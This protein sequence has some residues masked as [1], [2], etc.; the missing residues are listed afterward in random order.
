MGRASLSV[1][2]LP[3]TD[4]ALP[5]ARSTVASLAPAGVAFTVKAVRG[6]ADDSFSASL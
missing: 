4:T 1:T 2:A 3:L 5:D 6:G